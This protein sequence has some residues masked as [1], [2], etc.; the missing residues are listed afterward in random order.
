MANISTF[1]VGVGGKTSAILYFNEDTGATAQWSLCPD[2]KSRLI[3]DYPGGGGKE[4]WSRNLDPYF[5]ED[6]E[7]FIGISSPR[8]AD[9]TEKAKRAI[10]AMFGVL[11]RNYHLPEDALSDFGIE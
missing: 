11:E 8:F 4:G 5:L 6:V 1:A 10:Q 3:L 2:G 7:R 9:T